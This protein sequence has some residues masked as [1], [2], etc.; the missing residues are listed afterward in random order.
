M[1][2]GGTLGLDLAEKEKRRPRFAGRS[3]GDPAF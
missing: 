3:W 2:P 1:N